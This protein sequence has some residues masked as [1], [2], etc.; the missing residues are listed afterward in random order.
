M[1][2]VGRAVVLLASLALAGACAEPEPQGE[3]SFDDVEVTAGDDTGFTTDFDE[4]GPRPVPGI[5]GL[6]PPDFPETLPLYTPADLVDFG[7]G[8]R[9]E[10]FIVLQ[11]EAPLSGVRD[12]QL[13][14]L[15]RGGWRVSGGGDAWRA[16]RAGR[17]VRLTFRTEEGVSQIRYDY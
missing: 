4:I 1:S 8:A 14:R 15:R 9:R 12:E 3:R 7:A 17:T 11:V 2:R 5:N 16:D 10:R 13:A 6:I